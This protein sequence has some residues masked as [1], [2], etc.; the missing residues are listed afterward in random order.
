MSVFLSF[1]VILGYVYVYFLL[2]LCCLWAKLID[3]DDVDS[4][5]PA[6]FIF[7]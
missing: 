5:M 6:R 4:L 2:F 7:A 1:Y 3:D